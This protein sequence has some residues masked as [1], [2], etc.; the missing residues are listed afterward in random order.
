[1]RVGTVNGRPE[2]QLYR[3]V[4]ATRLPDG[5]I[6]IANAGT[7]TIRF[8]DRQGQYV[9]EVGGRGEGPGEF[10]GLT[11]LRRFGG[12]SLL[13]FDGRLHRLS[14]FDAAGQ[15]IRAFRLE[16]AIALPEFPLAGG[17]LLGS[18]RDLV[19]R[20][21]LQTGVNRDSTTVL[22]F[23]MEGV[24]GDTIGRFPTPETY[25]WVADSRIMTV[26]YPFARRVVSAPFETGFYFG[27]SDVYEIRAYG[28]DGAIRRIVR[29]EDADR[30]ATGADLERFQQATFADARDA[31]HRRQLQRAFDAM[32]VRPNLPAFVDLVADVAGY[33][34]VENYS[35]ADADAASWDVFDRQGRWL[36]VVSLPRNLQVYEIGVNSVLGKFTDLLDVEIVQV[37]HLVRARH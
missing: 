15:F 1:M 20:E 13:A 27:A 33:V 16:R 31:N 21:Q 6:V 36:G 8:Y 11:W 28:T 34:W 9:Q 32:S 14:V 26:P 10:A 3:V 35:R 22:R 37:H 7:N 17:R 18:T 5:Q 25:L 2:T 4:G 24:L 29:R 19:A 12:D 23:S 30:R